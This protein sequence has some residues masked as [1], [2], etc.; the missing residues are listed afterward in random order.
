MLGCPQIGDTHEGPLVTNP[1]PRH[2]TRNTGRPRAADPPP[3]PDRPAFPYPAS[4]WA[5]IVREL[6]LSPREAMLS[7][8]IVQAM[9]DKEIEQATGLA[10]GTIRTYLNRAFAKARARD[11]MEL[12]CRIT[13]EAMRILGEASVQRRDAQPHHSGTLSR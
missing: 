7:R 4:L 13:T 5:E 6:R 1:S 8:L 10:A 9:E 3:A 2:A 11:R 12:A